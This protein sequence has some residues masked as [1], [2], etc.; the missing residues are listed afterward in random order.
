[1]QKNKRFAVFWHDPEPSVGS[2]FKKVRPCVVV[3]PE[4]MNKVVN[5]VIVVPLTSTYKSWPFRTEVTV[6]GKKSHAAC[7]QARAVDKS[8][9]R[10]YITTLPV[11]ESKA[12]LQILEETFA[13]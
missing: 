3:S 13:D 10:E 2:E 12:V 8:R 11:I 1:M 7:D 9:L 4:M 6:S 5:T